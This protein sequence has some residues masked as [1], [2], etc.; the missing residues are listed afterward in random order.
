M[1]TTRQIKDIGVREFRDHAT[2]YLSGSDTLAIRKHGHLIGV[3]IPVNRD[4][5]DRSGDPLDRILRDAGMT[6]EEWADRV[7]LFRL[8]KRDPEKARAAVEQ[9]E[10]TMR[11][12]REETGMT[13][14]EFADL[15]DLNKPFEE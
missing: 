12:V 5:D 15:F 2:K 4:E 1:S 10:R 6:E 14:D 3:Y 8:R 13:E 7:D 11:Q 9:L